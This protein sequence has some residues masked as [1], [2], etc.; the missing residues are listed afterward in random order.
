MQIDQGKYFPTNLKDSG[1]Q[2]W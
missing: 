2:F 1:S